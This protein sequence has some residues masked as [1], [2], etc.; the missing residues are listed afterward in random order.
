MI[1]QIRHVSRWAYYPHRSS[2]YTSRRR[3]I[4]SG[5]VTAPIF[6][7]QFGLNNADGTPNKKK[8]NNISENVVAVLQAGAF[9]GAL[10]SALISARFGRRYTLIG[11][12]GVFIL[13][14]ILTTVAKGGSQGLAE[15]Y[16]GRVITGI[17]IGGIS[18]VA[19]AF[20]SECSPKEVRGRITGLFQI[21]VAFGVMMSYWVNYGIALHVKPGPKLW[22]IPF[23]IQLIPAGVML[24]G[25]L[26]VRESPR[27]L[28][29][30]GRTQEALDNLAYLRREPPTA[31]GVIHE[32]AEI[33][34]AIQEERDARRELGL[35]EAFL[36]KGNWI[37]FVIAIVIFL[38]QQ[39]S[40]Q[41]AVNYYAP[42]I[43]ASIGYTGRKNGLLATGIYGVIKVVA[44]AIFV[45]LG[46]EWLGRKASLFISA[47]GMGTCFFI[48][49]SILKTHPPPATSATAAPVGNPPAASKA[50][51][52][53]LYIFVCF[54]SMGWGP[55]PWVYCADIFPTRTRHFGLAVAS[56]SQWLFNF[57]L[58]RTTLQMETNLGYKIYLMFGAINIGGSA[59][60]SL[61]IPE[62]KGRSLE[63]MDVIFGAV[64]REKRQADIAKQ[65]QELDVRDGSEK[66]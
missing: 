24:L 57:V 53:M 34:A 5:V 45:F 46:V 27:Y 22:R 62:T 30:V 55:L 26:T 58:T 28:A 32:M 1:P 10:G 16:A 43:F 15:I 33:E 23:G 31:D 17:G 8:S 18:A 52:A 66:A 14:A 11:F 4:A 39:W 60:F 50:M 13:G 63:D 19:P 64:S 9:F 56:A 48:I 36:G 6:L 42:Q 61:F 49:G 29:S 54:Y 3:G 40:G 20:V 37:R 51:A 12:S 25:L 41:N 44:T 7:D 2:E 47:V 65:E 21:F 35:K 38:L 59:V